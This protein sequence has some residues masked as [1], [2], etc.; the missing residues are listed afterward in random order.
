LFRL[1]SL[2]GLANGVFSFIISWNI[3]V[4][5]ER[6]I[7]CRKRRSSAILREHLMVLAGQLGRD[8]TAQEAI[9][10]APPW[11]FRLRYPALLRSPAAR[12]YPGSGG[13]INYFTLA[14]LEA[15]RAP[16]FSRGV[17]SNCVT[18]CGKSCFALRGST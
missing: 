10:G 5:A 17:F 11:A 3:R 12:R 13:E 9:G 4:D 8:Y 15:V 18:S 14:E 16:V 1:N 6:L 7:L 2:P